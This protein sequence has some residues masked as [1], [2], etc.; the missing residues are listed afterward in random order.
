MFVMGLYSLATGK[1]RLKRIAGVTGLLPLPFT[2]FIMMPIIAAAKRNNPYDNHMLYTVIDY[3]FF[4]ICFTFWQ[5]LARQYPAVPADVEKTSE[6]RPSREW[7]LP[8]GTKFLGK[9]LYESKEGVFVRR[10]E[11]K[12]M[13]H[14]LRGQMDASDISYLES[15]VE[16]NMATAESKDHAGNEPKAQPQPPGD[17]S[18]R[19]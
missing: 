7:K 4:F 12:M 5:W 9:F 10:S 13:V 17:G 6:A 11:D 8:D 16:H 15:L 3:G 19:A 1:N 2:F 14:Y 18:T